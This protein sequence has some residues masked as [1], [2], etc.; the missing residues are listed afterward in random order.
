M[1]AAPQPNRRMAWTSR[2]ELGEEVSSAATNW[3]TS[4]PQPAVQ[5]TQRHE[6]D[7]GQR[8]GRCGAEVGAVLDAEP[9]L[10]QHVGVLAQ[11]PELPGVAQVVRDA[12]RR[13]PSG[14][15]TR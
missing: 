9:E 13:A 6:V 12:R 7:L 11:L 2:P 15:R 5:P 10:A 8:S 14:R 3:P 4:A 1:A